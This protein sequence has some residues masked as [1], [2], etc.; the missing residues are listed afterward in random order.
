M[1]G[2]EWIT[3]RHNQGAR[4]KADGSET[5]PSENMPALSPLAVASTSA[6]TASSPAAARLARPPR[7]RHRR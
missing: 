3:L 5:L 7:S 2:A 6:P 1:T 4:R